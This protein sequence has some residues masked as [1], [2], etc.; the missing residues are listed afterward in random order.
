M[1]A[2]LLYPYSI[3][4]GDTRS[5]QQLKIAITGNPLA[6]PFQPR[7]PARALVPNRNS[8]IFLDIPH[9]WSYMGAAERI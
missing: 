8:V 9:P 6:P 7:P 3:I 5:A 4:P 1:G 2:R